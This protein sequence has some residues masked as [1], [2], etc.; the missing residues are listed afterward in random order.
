MIKVKD[1]HL[2]LY[3]EP[4]SSFL[5]PHADCTNDF[6]YVGVYQQIIVKKQ[7]RIHVITVLSN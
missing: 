5:P 2:N 4:K 3:H 6:L 1:Q 7:P